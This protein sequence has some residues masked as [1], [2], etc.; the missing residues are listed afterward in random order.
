M[1]NYRRLAATA[2]LSFVFLLIIGANVK[3]FD[4]LPNYADIRIQELKYDPYPAEAGKYMDLW[5]KIEN[6]GADKAYVIC[7][8]EPLYPFHID[9][10]ENAT[11]IIGNLPSLQEN[12][13]Q[14]RIRVDPDA[15]DGWNELK[16]R[17][18]LKD[19]E[20]WNEEKLKIN[21]ES[22]RPG[23]AIGSLETEPSKL[24]PDTTDNKISVEIQNIGD[25]DAEM[26]TTR[27]YLP[28]GIEATDAYSDTYNIGNINSGESK[29]ATFYIDIDEDTTTTKNA[30]IVISYK[31]SNNN[32]ED[33]KNQT[34]TLEIPIKGIPFFKMTNITTEP[35]VISQG[36]NAK[37]HLTIENVGS[38]EAESVS[39]RIFKQNEQPFDF[40]ENYDYIGNIKPGKSG[41]VIFET[42]IDDKAELKTYLLRAE[43]RYI[44]NDDVKITEMQVPINIGMKKK[45]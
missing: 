28:S 32:R 21:I 23:F 19:S 2:A 29:I 17:C 7:E 30:N 14:Y 8:L 44:I 31:D 38:K 25:G 22:K 35:S 18:R 4:V 39:V 13:L 6:A 12:I 37:I 16:I 34:L 42:N 1:Y 33:Y 36:D 40:E 11:R 10:N 27:L 43:I 20:I 41:D 45:D 3:A 9:P 5:I 24:Y 26:A 15:V